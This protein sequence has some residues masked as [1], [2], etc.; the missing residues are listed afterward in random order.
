M[1]TE[2][3]IVLVVTIVHTTTIGTITVIDTIL[4]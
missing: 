2:R 4:N 1:L 3:I